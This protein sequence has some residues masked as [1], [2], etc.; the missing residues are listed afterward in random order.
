MPAVQSPTSQPG[1]PAR[2]W[3]T[4]SPS[5]GSRWCHS[6]LVPT[7]WG[8]RVLCW[9][10]TACQPTSDPGK[11]T[12]P[13]SPA[14]GEHVRV[15]HSH[16]NCHTRRHHQQHH[17]GLNLTHEGCWSHREGCNPWL[18]HPRRDGDTGQEHSLTAEQTWA[19]SPGHPAQHMGFLGCIKACERLFGEGQCL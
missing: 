16:E 4:A 11:G 5:S 17:L 18:L 1:I 7:V 10:L 2:Q 19:L 14:W 3:S 15:T 12:S 8:S 6:P 9:C 13:S